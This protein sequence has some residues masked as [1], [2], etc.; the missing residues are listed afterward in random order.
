MSSYIK[1]KPNR[2]IL[3][4]FRFHL[5]FYNMV[6]KKKTEEK[7]AAWLI[8][9]GRKNDIRKVKGKKALSTDKLIFREKLLNIGEAPIVLD[10]FLT[11]KSV[12][13]HSLFSSFYCM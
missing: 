1:Q 6:N 9:T 13:Q 10:T 4:V 7:K 11:D 8:K 12:K 5:W 2:K 3:G